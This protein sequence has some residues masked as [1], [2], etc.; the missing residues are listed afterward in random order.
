MNRLTNEDRNGAGERYAYDLCGNRLL[1]ELVGVLCLSSPPRDIRRTSL[2]ILMIRM[3]GI[4]LCGLYTG[5][6]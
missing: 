4:I 2:L 6:S 1:K 5:Q 3:I